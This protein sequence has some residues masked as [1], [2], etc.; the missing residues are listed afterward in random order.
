MLARLLDASADVGWGVK[1]VVS[2]PRESAS[3]GRVVCGLSSLIAS[4]RAVLDVES[5][6]VFGVLRTH[7]VELR[8][9]ALR[10]PPA[11]SEMRASPSRRRHEVKLRAATTPR[12]RLRR[13]AWSHSR[14]PDHPVRQAHHEQRDHTDASA[15]C[16]VLR[17]ACSVRGSIL[18][19]RKNRSKE[20]PAA[21]MA[22]ASAWVG[23]IS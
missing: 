6:C 11:C 19:A 12:F 4:F 3:F 10:C 5:R 9:L 17:D 18:T 21:L 16:D 22:T 8:S 23:S 1:S 15:R 13:M 14:S 20:T 2:H 7:A